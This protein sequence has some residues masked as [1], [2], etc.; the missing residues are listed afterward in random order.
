MIG[1][2]FAAGDRVY[3]F[4]FAPRSQSRLMTGVVIKV[5]RTMLRVEH[6]EGA[7]WVRADRV[8]RAK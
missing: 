4:R 1:D 8:H 6:G 2:V 7:T 5:T 3:W